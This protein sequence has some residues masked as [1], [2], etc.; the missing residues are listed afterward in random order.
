MADVIVLGAG[1]VGLSVAI[2][3]Q[4]RGRAV[5]LLDR[6]EPG[7]ETSY[8]NAGIIQTEAVRPYR[9]PR[10]LPTLLGVAGNRR[11]DA[12]YHWRALPGLAPALARYWWHSA[13]ARYRGL[14]AQY[15]TLIR[16][17]QAEHAELIAASGAGDL[18]QR[19][20]YYKLYRDP[21]ALAAALADAEQVRAEYGIP[22][23]ALDAAQV[24]RL[25]PDLRVAVAGALHWPEPWT[26]RDPAALA[27]AYA[28]YFVSLGGSLV[29]GDAASLRRQGSGWRVE[30]RD[31]PAEAASAVIALG[32]WAGEATRR[33]GYRLPLFVKRGYHMHYRPAGSAGLGNWLYDADNYYLITPMAQGIRLTTGAEFAALAAPPTPG[34]LV[35][36]ER[37]ARALFPL[38]ERVDAA[39][40][41]GAR[42]CTPDM[43]PV[44]GPAPCH[45]GLWFAFGHGHHGFTLGPIS[46]RLLAERMVGAADPADLAPFGAERFLRQPPNGAVAGRRRARG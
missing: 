6:R 18:V 27:A 2:H 36:A 21:A 19:R 10:D 38:G 5:L 9:F 29:R 45:D 44:I 25:E 4:R 26:V 16:R 34:Q 46:G 20:G 22:H 43:K 41:L 31:G 24:A 40:W 3:L 8:G 33:L 23:G 11:V 35:A 14:A 37:I 42:P 32:P 1:M 12:R 13:P 28:R 15:A 17:A 39:P 30:T 7:Y